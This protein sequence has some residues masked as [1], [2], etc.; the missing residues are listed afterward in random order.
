MSKD[1]VGNDFKIL[2]QKYGER[3]AK[4][5]REYF[6][7]ILAH[8]GV[9]SKFIIENFA[10]N[11]FLY[12]DIT[13][14]YEKLQQFIKFVQ[15]SYQARVKAESSKSSDA[16][17]EIKTPE[18]LL[19]SVGYTLH[20]CETFED[21]K[22]FTKY[23]QKDEELCTFRDEYR[24]IDWHVFFAVKNDAESIKRADDPSRDDEYGTSV[25]SIQFLKGDESI[26]SIKNRY[27]HTVE[28]PDATFDNDLEKIVPGLT[29][30]FEKHYGIKLIEGAVKN[31]TLPGYV[32][33]NDGRMY[34]YNY[35]INN[36]QY[37]SNNI[38]IKN[39]EVIKLDKSRYEMFDYFI[40]D[41][42]EKK[43]VKFDETLQDSFT[44]EIKN[45]Q[46]IETSVDKDKKLRVLKITYRD[47]P[48]GEDK[49][50]IV[51]SDSRGRLIE[52]NS[53]INPKSNNPFLRYSKHI[54]SLILPKLTVLP[55]SSLSEASNIEELDLRSVK[56]IKDRVLCYSVHAD[57]LEFPNLESIGDCSL[58]NM[59]D[60]RRLYIPKCKSIGDGSCEMARNLSELY[61][62][63]LEKIGY[64]CFSNT[65][66]THIS[67]PSLVRM[68]K[69]CFSGC[70]ARSVDLPNLVDMGSRCF[71]NANYLRV[72]NLPKAASIGQGCFMFAR[73]LKQIKIDEC[74]ELGDSCFMESKNLEELSAKKLMTMS[75]DCFKRTEKLK[76][77]RLPSLEMMGNHCFKTNA[78]EELYLD[79]IKTMGD[80]SFFAAD[81]LT[82]LYAPELESITHS[83]TSINQLES[84]SLPRLEKIMFRAFQKA[85]NLKFFE[86]PNLRFIEDFILEEAQSLTHFRADKIERL[87]ISLRKAPSLLY[88]YAPS[89]KNMDYEVLM[90]SKN[91]KEIVVSPEMDEELLE[92]LKNK[93]KVVKNNDD[94][95]KV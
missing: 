94:N 90:N 23:Y 32:V 95:E 36:I 82:T 18:E 17:E 80:G 37:C 87:S 50:F 39:G 11:E 34:P 84:L 85:P 7:T 52:V 12:E 62:D 78:V 10:E 66:L 53:E 44:E 43:F 31:F 51:K 92:E 30:S 16:T 86:A 46:K 19:A 60:V 91:L 28:D 49:Y 81:N 48:D 9:L 35:E 57:N 58:V 77:V 59:Y 27:N 64:Y 63:E 65:K 20:K 56:V 42:V 22:K 6:P 29:E 15:G 55:D 33:A 76:E 67:L 71:L 4:L 68:N 14:S 26:I 72:L 70:V 47:T 83:F 5:C 74:I 21:T 38:I 41:K 40:F 2:K 54:K 88:F 79:K 13:Q 93:S 45:V 69:Q 3:F 73:E 61:A 24:T 1:I 25:I 75:D 8:D 89:L